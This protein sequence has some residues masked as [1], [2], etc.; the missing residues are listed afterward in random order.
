MVTE[1]STY[2]VSVL[3]TIV[4]FCYVFASEKR[5]PTISFVNGFSRR[6]QHYLDGLPE[7]FGPVPAL[8]AGQVQRPL[9]G[10]QPLL[11]PEVVGLQLLGT[12][13]GRLQLA[14]G[15]RLAELQRQDLLVELG[16]QG[17]LV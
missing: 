12:G 13:G 11:G 5:Q 1:L 16:D 9:P 17:L 2:L 15:G 8:L 7:V 3:V 6:N 10:V 14:Q 4:S